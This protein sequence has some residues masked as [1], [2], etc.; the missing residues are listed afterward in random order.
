MIGARLGKEETAINPFKFDQNRLRVSRRL[1]TMC[2]VLLLQMGAM[3][4]CA[5]AA[6]KSIGHGFSQKLDLQ[7]RVDEI[8]HV[9]SIGNNEL[10]VVVG[11]LSS[12]KPSTALDAPDDVDYIEIEYSANISENWSYE[13]SA[14]RITSGNF[15]RTELTEDFLGAGHGVSAEVSGD[16]SATKLSWFVR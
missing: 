12:L 9:R 6:E 4:F 14:E 7:A 3:L 1:I 11:Q 13:F 10:E 5:Y 16:I 8:R 2:L 15:L